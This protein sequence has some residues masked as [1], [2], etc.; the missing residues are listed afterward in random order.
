MNWEVILWSSITF[1][2]LICTAG[3]II[4]IVSAKNV[5][6]RKKDLK[7]VH[8]TLKTGSKVLFAG[9]LYGKVVSIKEDSIEV[10][11]SKGII[12]EATR[13]SIQSIYS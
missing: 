4:S 3:F 12:V 2:F 8:T 7:D 6:Q 1:G 11:I 5:R 9:G 13:Y 10:E